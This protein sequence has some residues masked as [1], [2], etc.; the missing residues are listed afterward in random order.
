M[1]TTFPQVGQ[2]GYGFRYGRFSVTGG[3]QYMHTYLDL[4]LSTATGGTA[5]TVLGT[6]KQIS[7]M[8]ICRVFRPGGTAADTYGANVGLL[9]LDFHYQLCGNGSATEMAK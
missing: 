3:N 1:G 9:E 7:S 4:D 8:L 5:G 6:G 2:S